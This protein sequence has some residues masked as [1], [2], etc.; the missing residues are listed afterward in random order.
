M[1]LGPHLPLEEFVPL[2]CVAV[3]PGVCPEAVEQEQAR[4]SVSPAWLALLRRGLLL[5][6]SSPA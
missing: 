6:L 5:A 4:S 2:R 1:A 3:A